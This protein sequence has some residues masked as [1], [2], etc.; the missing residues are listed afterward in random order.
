MPTIEEAQAALD[1]WD[2]AH[3]VGPTDPGL[4]SMR[5]HESP[6]KRSKDLTA[7]LNRLRREATERDRLEKALVEAKR[8]ERLAALPTTPVDPEQ[9]KGATAVLV[10]QHGSW[11]EWQRV[12]RVNRTTVTCWAAPGM[13]QPR[14]P[15]HRIVGV[16][17]HK[18][19]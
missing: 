19:G 5:F 2:A 8:A 14:Y 13:D 9:L 16:R 3:Q 15:H 17:H 4:Q 10:L 18:D 7:Y 1:A 11:V 12:I 6:A